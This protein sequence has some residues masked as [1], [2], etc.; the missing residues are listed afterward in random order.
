[1][2]KNS[3]QSNSLDSVLLFCVLTM[4]F[5][6]IFIVLVGCLFAQ[7]AVITQTMCSFRRECLTN[8]QIEII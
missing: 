8:I 4:Y 5:Q 3:K 6:Y 2:S 7:N 1:M